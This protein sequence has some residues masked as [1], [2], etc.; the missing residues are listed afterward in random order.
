MPN[1]L[2]IVLQVFLHH[3]FRFHD[4]HRMSGEV[5]C[6]NRYKLCIKIKWPQKV[7]NPS[8]W[9]S[10]HDT[11]EA[12][13]Q[14]IRKRWALLSLPRLKGS[15]RFGAWKFL[16]S[17]MFFRGIMSMGVSAS[18]LIQDNLGCLRLW[19]VMM[20]NPEY[21]DSGPSSG[22]TDSS[23]PQVVKCHQLPN[24]FSLQYL[25]GTSFSE[26]IAVLFVALV[27]KISSRI[28]TLLHQEM[29]KQQVKQCLR[30]MINE[31]NFFK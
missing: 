22:S 14:W 18:A 28:A 26:R 20:T 9:H 30:T 24:P 10:N 4:S 7:P 5:W 12:K 21:T 27:W 2:F 29:S 8:Q 15:R 11:N 17:Q 1:F 23:N 3:E 31:A 25:R 13:F 6:R 16:V 19:A